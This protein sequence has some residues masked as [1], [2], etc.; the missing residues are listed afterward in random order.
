MQTDDIDAYLVA[1]TH[2]QSMASVPPD[3][4]PDEVLQQVLEEEQRDVGGAVPRSPLAELTSA[5]ANVLPVN[6]RA[7]AKRAAKKAAPKQACAGGKRPLQPVAP[8]VTNA[9]QPA[10]CRICGLR[11][12]TARDCQVR[13]RA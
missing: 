7:A 13:V 4:I 10:K 6:Q 8:G 9:R 3:Q 5:E 1:Q 11:G 12:R 2:T